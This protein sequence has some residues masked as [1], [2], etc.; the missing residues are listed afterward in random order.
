MRDL[1]IP[2]MADIRRSL[3][4]IRD[5]ETRGAFDETALQQAVQAA[6]RAELDARS[7]QGRG[8]IG[9]VIAAKVKESSDVARA[10]SA[11]TRPGGSYVA[12]QVIL[13]LGRVRFDE[14]EED[15]EILGEGAFGVVQAGKY[16]GQEVAIKKARGVIGDSGVTRGFR[17]AIL[18]S[19]H[20]NEIR[21]LP[22]PWN[23][24][25]HEA[26]RI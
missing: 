9:D 19:S 7:S 5:R 22:L 4:E 24:G 3:R 1:H 2:M 12:G 15:D 8:S 20:R 6:I 18:F 14:L 25:V 13:R 16:R 23:H 10:A 21:S 26:G 11:G 17:W